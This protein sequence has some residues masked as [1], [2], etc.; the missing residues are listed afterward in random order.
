VFLDVPDNGPEPPLR[1]HAIPPAL[2]FPSVG[3][4]AKCPSGSAN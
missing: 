3:I 4:Q 2:S 1:E